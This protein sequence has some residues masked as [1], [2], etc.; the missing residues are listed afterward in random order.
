[1]NIEEIEQSY[2]ENIGRPIA[3]RVSEFWLSSIATDNKSRKDFIKHITAQPEY[4]EVKLKAFREIYAKEVPKGDPSGALSSFNEFISSSPADSLLSTRDI[5]EFTRRL[6]EC[7]AAFNQ[8][9][10]TVYASVF[11]GKASSSLGKS[12]DIGDNYKSL[13]LSKWYTNAA[14]SSNDLRMDME[15]MPAQQRA[16]PLPTAIAATTA[17]TSGAVTVGAQSGERNEFMDAFEKEFG[18]PMFVQEYFK[19]FEGWKL[20]DD[21]QGHV[22]LRGLA[23]QYER[24]KERV[25]SIMDTFINKIISDYEFVKT[26]LDA[27]DLGDAFYQQL[28]RDVISSKEYESVIKAKIAEIHADLY[29]CECSE[30][31]HVFGKVR[32]ARVPCNKEALSSFVI[33][34]RA[35]IEDISQSI[36]RVYS[37][38]L[39]REPDQTETEDHFKLYLVTEPLDMQHGDSEL[40]SMLCA[41]LEFHDVIKAE[42]RAKSPTAHKSPKLLFDILEKVLRD[43]RAVKLRGMQEAVASLI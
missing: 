31:D 11:P 37:L 16:S 5:V 42:I 36:V 28:E 32:D 18:R 34:F 13:F 39:G 40:E 26:Y 35:Q 25:N 8:K 24:R 20:S 23:T 15:K 21:R 17:T 2:I 43:D 12:A 33:D 29:D 10:A 9:I 30:I 14:Y 6:P 1:M 22:M 41:S 19:Y 4:R 7:T 3:K 27:C 38:C